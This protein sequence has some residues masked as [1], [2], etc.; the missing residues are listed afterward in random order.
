M[1]ASGSSYSTTD[2]K[3]ILNNEGI[4]LHTVFGRNNRIAAVFWFI[5]IV[6]WFF[7]LTLFKH[8]PV[9]FVWLGLALVLAV[10]RFFLANQLVRYQTRNS[11]SDLLGLLLHIVIFAKGILVSLFALNVP[12][13]S[14]GD[15]VLIAI[16]M[17][18][19]TM[20]SAYALAPSFIAFFL[21]TVPP[22]AALTFRLVLSPGILAQEEGWS[23]TVVITGMVAYVL[24][25]SL[26][27]RSTR[28]EIQRATSLT[29]ALR[30]ANS[31][32][33]K[34]ARDL[35]NLADQHSQSASRAEEAS[36]TKSRILT[37]TSHELRTPMNAVLG[38]AQSLKWETDEARRQEQLDLLLSAG[39]DLKSLLNDIID[40]SRIETGQSIIEFR[41]ADPHRILRSVVQLHS[42]SA[43]AKGLEINA[44]IDEDIP[45][46]LLLDPVRLR[47]CF[48]NLISNAIKFTDTG[49]IDVE[50]QCT[51][52]NIPA[53][54]GDE[55]GL[56]FVIRD[57]G[58]GIS[59]ADQSTLF[60][61][62]SRAEGIVSRA[63]PGAGLGLAITRDL[64]RQM[65]GDLTVEST[66]GVGSVFTFTWR[67][68]VS[69]RTPHPDRPIAPVA[70]ET[71]PLPES[72]TLLVAEDHPA[73]QKVI[74]QFLKAFGLNV[75]IANSGVDL[76]KLASEE[77]YPAMLVDLH[78]PEMSG[79][80][81]I[82][83]IRSSE[84]PN[85][86]TPIV[87]LTADASPDVIRLSREKGVEAHIAKP[88]D[89][90]ELFEVLARILSPTN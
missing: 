54:A 68:V 34:Q 41:P 18:P 60:E 28:Y 11:R 16:F 31:Q 66:A 20:G 4:D 5:V 70:S 65:G 12:I 47:Q 80:D 19:T 8:G 26:L 62:F 59:D 32:I 42:Q 14:F 84:G 51:T 72:Q 63:R 33:E 48:G 24:Y 49:R 29:N 17:V 73:N 89:A 27:A 36:L 3:P 39:R 90:N 81:A 88:I 45:P 44:S 21:H 85:K 79:F 38:M 82:D 25:L 2:I 35:A 57:T 71:T 76:I 15:I 58:I 10:T 46:T 74:T 40:L 87:M 61:L 67:A 43:C 69:D 13:D 23:L 53:N 56:A 55:I 78:M 75:K 64:A 86:T 1:D 30:H 37:N 6:G 9:W 77:A 83:V 52:H 22:I 50:L 7:T